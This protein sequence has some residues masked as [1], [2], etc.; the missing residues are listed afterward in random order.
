MKDFEQIR[1]VNQIE[2]EI[3]Q[4]SLSTLSSRIVSHLEEFKNSLYVIIKEKTS[5]NNFPKIHLFSRDLQNLIK[6]MKLKDRISSG[7]L[8]FGFIKKGKFFLSIEG[9]EFLLIRNLISA[10]VQ[11]YVNRHG[12]KS[13]LYGNNILK[14][15]L[16]KESYNFKAKDILFILNE[17]QEI[18]AICRAVVEYSQVQNLEPEE[19]IAINLRDKGIYLREKQ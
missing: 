7:G 17:A 2:T 12:E 11:L 6:N 14:N 8:Y 3:I 9:A 5:H 13:I 4:A 15:M 19:L 18:I 10:N 16:I 1:S